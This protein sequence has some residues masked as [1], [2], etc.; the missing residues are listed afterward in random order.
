MDHAIP[1]PPRLLPYYV[2]MTR[3]LVPSHDEIKATT[4]STGKQIETTKSW[5]D[6]RLGFKSDETELK[7]TANSAAGNRLALL[8]KERE[9]D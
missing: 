6:S 8:T 2:A 3:S 5:T 1:E 9:P 4:Y 7:T